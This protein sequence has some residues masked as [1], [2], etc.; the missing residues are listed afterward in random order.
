MDISDYRAAV[1]ANRREH[2]FEAVDE[3]TDA[4]ERLWMAHETDDTLG[5]VAVLATVVE[6]DGIGAD[7]SGAET[8]DDIA[9]SFRDMLADAVD[10]RPERADGGEAPTPIGYVT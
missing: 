3:R 9:A 2:G 1:A 10:P 7:G 6:A 8:L 5:E 4:F